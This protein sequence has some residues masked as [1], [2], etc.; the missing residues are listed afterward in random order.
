MLLALPG[1]SQ[2]EV[3]ISLGCCGEDGLC[4]R[5]GTHWE[6][7]LSW[8][9]CVACESGSTYLHCCFHSI[10]MKGTDAPKGWPWL[11]AS[12]LAKN[13]T[14]ALTFMCVLSHEAWALSLQLSPDRTFARGQAPLPSG[15]HCSLGLYKPPP[16]LWACSAQ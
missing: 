12:V 10:R 13:S 5:S 16:L 15:L 1:F 8:F 2:R 3:P 9:L 6:S 14:D 11:E 7:P 4:S